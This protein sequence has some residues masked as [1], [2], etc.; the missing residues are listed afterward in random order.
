[1]DLMDHKIGIPVDFDL[2][3]EFPW[4]LVVWLPMPVGVEKFRVLELV[5][6]WVE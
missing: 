4:L 2:A 1:M 3:G 6:N 5:Q